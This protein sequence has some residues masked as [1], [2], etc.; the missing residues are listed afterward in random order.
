MCEFLV[1]FSDPAKRALAVSR[2]GKH[3]LRL[4]YHSA[5]PYPTSRIYY[6][7]SDF[8]NSHVYSNSLSLF[9]TEELITA[10]FLAEDEAYSYIQQS[11]RL[12]RPFFVL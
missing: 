9:Q 5:V 4:I 12:L 2:R 6:K 8:V 11:F 3:F 1:K 10:V 7:Q